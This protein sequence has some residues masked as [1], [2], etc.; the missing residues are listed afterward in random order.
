MVSIKRPLFR[1]ETFVLLQEK[2]SLLPLHNIWTESTF[3]S[4]MRSSF[5]LMARCTY[6]V[7]QW[8]CSACEHF[9]SEL[10]R[11]KIRRRG[12][13]GRTGEMGRG[14]KLLRFYS[15]LP[16]HHLSAIQFGTHIIIFV[17][18]W[19]YAHRKTKTKHCILPIWSLSINLAYYAR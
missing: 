13:E 9:L 14:K 2:G 16:W 15:F 12:E 19:P 11:V 7:A 6:T 17:H 5:F 18:T 10:E 1:N 4:I 3:A 8:Q